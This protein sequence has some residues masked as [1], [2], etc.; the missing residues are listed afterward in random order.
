MMR[1]IAAS[2]GESFSRAAMRAVLPLTLAVIAVLFMIQ[3]RGTERVG[4]L[5][6]PIMILWFGTLAVLGAILGAFYPA[7]KAAKQDPIEALA[8]E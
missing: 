8:Y 7:L 3:R 2:T 6:G 4:R 5:F 1:P